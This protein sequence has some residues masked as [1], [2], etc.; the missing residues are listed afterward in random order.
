[1]DYHLEGGNGKIHGEDRR[2]DEVRKFVWTSRG[3]N[4]HVSG[5]KITSSHFT[6][7]ATRN[8]VHPDKFTQHIFVI[9]EGQIEN[10]YGPIEWEIH[11]PGRAYAKWAA[12]MAV[13]LGTG[14][15]WIMCK[16]ENAPDPIVS[17]CR[18]CVFCFLFSFSIRVA[19]KV[20]KTLVEW[21]SIASVHE[22]V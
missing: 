11:A 13:G 2:H 6:N 8:E 5:L 17:I 10:E 12:K 15:P 4:Y 7:C 1:M 16:Q 22:E 14:V 21:F 20:K 3:S 9:F 19:S 18:C